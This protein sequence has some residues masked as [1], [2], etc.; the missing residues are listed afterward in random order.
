MGWRDHR[1]D[2]SHQSVMWCQG[3]VHRFGVARARIYRYHNLVHRA[4]LPKI[5][6]E[7]SLE[8]DFDDCLGFAV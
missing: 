8:T 1:V 2:V 3:V 6:L 4:R 7:S 5:V